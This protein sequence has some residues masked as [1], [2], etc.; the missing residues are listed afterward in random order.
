MTDSRKKGAVFERQ[1]V[2]YI[3]DHLGES[4]PELPK[5]NLSQYQI[6]GEA[7]IVIP[8]WS[9]ECKAYASGSTYKQAWWEQACAAS[10]DRFP[11]L[12]YK[13]NNR[14][15]RC[16]I[17]LMAIC[18]DFSYDPSLVAEISLPTWVQ[19]VRESYGIFDC[20]DEL[21]QAGKMAYGNLLIDKKN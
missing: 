1:I 15:I 18:R 11:V 13:F 12:I 5:R 17:Q 19:V 21:E 4:L 8:G 9:I 14:P 6:K 16:V 2:N 3:K 20:E 10:G 7:D